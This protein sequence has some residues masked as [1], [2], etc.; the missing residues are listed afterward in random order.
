[1]NAIDEV[2][3]LSLLRNKKTREKGF[4]LLLSVYKEP[5]YWHIRRMVRWHEDADD[6][7]QNTMLKI[8]KGIDG[9]KEKS[10]LYTWMYRIASNESLSHLRKRKLETVDGGLEQLEYKLKE[11]PYF[12]GDSAQIAL[13]KA[14]D[15]LPPKQKLVFSM[16]YFDETPYEEM[17]GVLKTS[18]G[19]LKA[20][21]HHACKKIEAFIRKH[22]M[23]MP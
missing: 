19:S 6:V 17:S 22:E 23:N 9:F 12:D 1:M 7:L 15:T 3:I 13:E 18:V 5:L 8:F 4:R 20:S 10:S 14:M 21:Y 2:E 16:R 11:D